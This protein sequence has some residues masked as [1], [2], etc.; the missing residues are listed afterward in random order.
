MI[1]L[2]AVSILAWLLISPVRSV[3]EDNLV[4]W[5]AA[6]EASTIA[7]FVAGI[8]GILFALLPLEFVEGKKLWNY[9]RLAWFS[10]ALPATFLFFHV[11]I[12]FEDS[13]GSDNSMTLLIVGGGLVAV[14]SLLWLFFRL[15]MGSGEA[16]AA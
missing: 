2:L 16:E 6:L 3:S 14:S 1:A 11:V 10:A 9:S 15:R 5:A 4:W 8:E 7:I 13:I 12:G